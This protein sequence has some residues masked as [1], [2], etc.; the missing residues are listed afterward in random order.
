[1]QKKPDETASIFPL[2]TL[3]PYAMLGVASGGAF[4]CTM[5]H[6]DHSTDTRDKV[7]T[8]VSANVPGPVKPALS[9][10][11]S[12]SDLIASEMFLPKKTPPPK[13]PY[14]D[15]NITVTE[16]RG[17]Y[18]EEDVTKLAVEKTIAV[19]RLT[20][21]GLDRNRFVPGYLDHGGQ[22]KM[23]FYTG[24]TFVI[25]ETGEEL[26][27]LGIGRPDERSAHLFH[28]GPGNLDYNIKGNGK[29]PFAGWVTVKLC[30]AMIEGENVTVQKTIRSALNKLITAKVGIEEKCK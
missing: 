17:D 20:Q 26:Y 3:V 1:M 28:E 21:E 16:V 29:E 9:F 10:A 5:K 24:G 13:V 30:V 12:D 23:G 19:A 6:L 2:K 15:R 11:V 14:T 4:V 18:C 25:K 8:V 22:G 7:A 27:G